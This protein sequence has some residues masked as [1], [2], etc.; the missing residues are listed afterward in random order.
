MPKYLTSYKVNNKKYGS[1]IYAKSFKEAESIAVKRNIGETI[2]GLSS[3]D[4]TD[5]FGR[6]VPEQLQNPTFTDLSDYDFIKQLPA[7]IHTACFLSFIQS[8]S[9]DRHIDTLSDEGVLHELIHLMTIQDTTTRE[10]R[11]TRGKFMTLQN[12]IHGYLKEK[13]IW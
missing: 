13:L 10:I 12:S 6:K 1:H 4:A 3:G 11:R 7:I 9:S 5:G 8:R 2:I